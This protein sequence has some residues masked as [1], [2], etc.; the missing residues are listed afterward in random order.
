MRKRIFTK[1]AVRVAKLLSWAPPLHKHYYSIQRYGIIE[2]QMEENRKKR[3]CSLLLH[4]NG[5]SLRQDG[6]KL[7]E[8]LTQPV[9]EQQLSV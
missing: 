2:E 3:V 7:I 1:I 8:P 6:W 4:S 9:P 5:N